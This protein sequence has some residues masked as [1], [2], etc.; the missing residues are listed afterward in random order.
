MECVPS[1]LLALPFV[2]YW[3]ETGTLLAGQAL[4]IAA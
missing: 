3:D 2:I 1:L 4:N